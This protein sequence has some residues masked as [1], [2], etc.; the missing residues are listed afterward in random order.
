M[1]QLR[2]LH[3]ATGSQSGA[4]VPASGVW[5]VVAYIATMLPSCL[6][7]VQIDVQQ[8]ANLRSIMEKAVSVCACHT[9]SSTL[10]ALCSG[11]VLAFET[12]KAR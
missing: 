9:S 7:V 8:D 11:L 3:D 1:K 10:L 5:D 4:L 2:L 12:I 6:Q